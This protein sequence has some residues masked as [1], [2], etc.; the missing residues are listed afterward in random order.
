MKGS[1]NKA[2]AELRSMPD[3]ELQMKA[4]EL[5]NYSHRL[6]GGYAKRH[7]RILAEARKRGL[8]VPI[9][10]LSEKAALSSSRVEQDE[11]ESRLSDLDRQ[12]AP[13]PEPTTS[14]RWNRWS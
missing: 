13:Q 4:A 2:V 12:L 10:G 5:S 9:M 3:K 7:R 11:F 6:A 14:Y 8:E 1:E